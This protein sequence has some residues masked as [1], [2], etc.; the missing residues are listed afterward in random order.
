[1]LVASQNSLRDNAEI[2]RENQSFSWVAF[3]RLA[4]VR[5]PESRLRIREANAATW[6]IV[7]SGDRTGSHPVQG[8]PGLNWVPATQ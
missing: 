4:V 6:V 1:M 3:L 8:V 2:D 7:L 5:F